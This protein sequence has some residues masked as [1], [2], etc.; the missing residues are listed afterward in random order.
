MVAFY[1]ISGECD[2]QYNN[3]EWEYESDSVYVLHRFC[4]SPKVQNRGIAQKLYRHNGYESRG[5]ADW[6]KG[7][8]DLMEKKL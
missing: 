7:R 2:E 8:F 3:A 4:V 1:A 5:Y 6:R